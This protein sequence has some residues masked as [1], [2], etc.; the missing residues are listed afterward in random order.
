M[1]T[2]LSEG[3]ARR[4]SS[5]NPA[6][7]RERILT[8]A[9]QLFTAQGVAATSMN[10]IAQ[11]AQVGAG[12]LYRHFAHK[13]K[14]CEAL[15]WDDFAV[16]Q[17]RADAVINGPDAPTAA[18]TRLHNLL[19]ELID[20]TLAH[21]PMLTAMQENGAGHQHTYQGPIYSWAHRQLASLLTAA[22]ARGEVS[23][24]DV[25]FT[26]DAILASIAPPLLAFQQQ[27]RGFN[28]AR[29]T[30]GVRRIFIDGLRQADQA[31]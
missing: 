21:I 12:T 29:I 6:V 22:A 18:L 4:Q 28:S 10:Q 17:A 15:M 27:Q 14:L 23:N 3:K 24:L 7:N 9:R 31:A 30:D 13:S 2:E 25:E 11:E 1:D 5:R 20:L 19:I 8:A 16:F 26:A